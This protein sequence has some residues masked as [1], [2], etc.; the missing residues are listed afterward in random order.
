MNRPR[1]PLKNSS[2]A[3]ENT[4]LKS[5]HSGAPTKSSEVDS[6]ASVSFEAWTNFWFTPIHPVGLHIV[7]FLAGLLFTL[8]LITL[9]GHQ[10]SFFGLAGWVDR[11][12]ATRLRA[13]FQTGWSVLNLFH[14][15]STWVHAA[16]WGAI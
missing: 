16:Y 2:A 5:S 7:R 8:W 1:M 3:L 13:D 12:A 10:T 15:N 11:D 9:A 4:P 14:S 6:S